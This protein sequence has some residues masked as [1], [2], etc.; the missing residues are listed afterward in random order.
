[1]SAP[2]HVVIGSDGTLLSLDETFCSIMKARALSLVGRNLRSITAP[3]DR[4]ECDLAMMRLTRKGIPFI[5]S[6]R[7]VRDDRSLIWVKNSVSRTADGIVPTLFMASVEPLIA[8]PAAR[9]PATLLSSARFMAECRRDMRVVTGEQLFGSEP[10]WDT[11]L[12]SYIAEAEGRMVIAD[13]L[14]EMLG[15][16]REAAD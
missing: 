1:M 4:E 6:K 8:Q 3:A 15:I 9:S 7:L 5:I 14:A 12:A 13:T 2:G 11:I 16:S 10:V